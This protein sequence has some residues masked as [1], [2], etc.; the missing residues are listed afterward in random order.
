MSFAGDSRNEKTKSVCS[1]G[2]IFHAAMKLFILL[3]KSSML[4]SSAQMPGKLL[5]LSFT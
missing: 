1:S 5:D 3:M 2:L 4:F